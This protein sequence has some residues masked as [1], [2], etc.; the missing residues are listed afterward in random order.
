MLN[1]K[2]LIKLRRI[3]GRIH[4]TVQE[5]RVLREIIKEI[6]SVDKDTFLLLYTPTHG[7]LGDHAIASAEKQ[8]L[9]KNEIVFYEIT[10][11]KLIL[12]NKHNKLKI[13]NKRKILI[14]GGGYLGTLWPYAEMMIRNI[15]FS[16]S[17]SKILFFPNTIFYED[18]KE[19][20]IEDF[21]KIMNL[22]SNAVICLREQISFDFAQEYFSNVLLIPDI[23]LS[24]EEIKGNFNRTGCL[25]CFRNDVEKTINE[26]LYDTVNQ[27]IKEIYGD[28]IIY[29]DMVVPYNIYPENRNEELS[30]KY[31]QF[32][33]AELVVTDRLH[34]MLFA[35]IT[36]TPCIVL[37][38]KSPKVKGCYEWI[39]NL[40][41][42]HFIEDTGCIES[43]CKSLKGKTGRYDNSAFK[44]YFEKLAEVIKEM[45]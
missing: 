22:N 31:T 27:K 25:M 18:N 37:D 13:L 40:E 2:K 44:S 3:H 21:V 12:L 9:K 41:Y 38:S 23:V 26:R 8:F 16:C 43:V 14:H 6:K 15:I 28:D 39:R 45:R 11:K 32:L 4:D 24:L 20:R 36:G 30:K 34:G 1:K 10:D 33:G 17:K 5:K 7:N 35:A 29:T 19:L 42:I